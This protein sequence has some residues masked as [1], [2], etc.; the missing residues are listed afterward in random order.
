MGPPIVIEAGLFVP[1]VRARSAASPIGETVSASWRG[2]DRDSC[3]AASPPTNGSHHATGPVGHRQVILRVEIRCVNLVS[4]RRNC[5][6]D[7]SAI[8]PATPRV[9]NPCGTVLR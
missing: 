7:R 6:R 2:T 1:E 4:G 8:G 5:V 9:T 3:S